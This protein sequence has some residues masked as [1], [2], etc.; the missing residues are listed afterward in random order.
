MKH[1]R[2]LPLLALLAVQACHPT[3]AQQPMAVQIPVAQSPN[4]EG[5]TP[6]REA[7]PESGPA[8]ETPFPKIEHEVLAN[9]LEMELVP[10]H[11]LPLVQ[12]RVVV[13]SRGAADGDRTGGANR[14][15]HMLKDGGAGRYASRELVAK[16]ESLGA[17][18]GIEVSPDS[19]VLSLS[20]PKR[21]FDEALDLLSAVTR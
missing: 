1:A 12:L 10:V 3:T 6:V 2:S 5:L 7:P 13:K 21:H 11:A 8:R 14:P 15:A 9:G 20:V 4:K 18:L 19:T 17:D 16:I